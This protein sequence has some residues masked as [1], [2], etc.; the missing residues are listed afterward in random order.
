[1]C[2]FI[3][4]SLLWRWKWSDAELQWRQRMAQHSVG[5]LK[6]SSQSLSINI[7]TVN[8]TWQLPTAIWQL[9]GSWT[10]LPDRRTCFGEH[11]V[12]SRIRQG[13]WN[14]HRALRGSDIRCLQGFPF[15]R[16]YISDL[17]IEQTTQKARCVGCWYILCTGKLGCLLLRYPR[18]L[19]IF[20]S[21]QTHYNIIWQTGLYHATSWIHTYREG[22]SRLLQSGSQKPQKDPSERPVIWPACPRGVLPNSQHCS[23]HGLAEKGNSW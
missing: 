11:L 8:I 2:H 12:L 3:V 13:E 7:D 18:T 17:E 10:E 15:P 6:G 5:I 23:C 1:M 9:K 19:V 22:P 4:C 14:I 20:Q 21:W 16:I